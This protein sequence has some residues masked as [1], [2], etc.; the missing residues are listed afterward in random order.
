M[1]KIAI[2]LRELTPY[3]PLTIHKAIERALQHTYQTSDKIYNEV[4]RLTSSKMS[5]A[6]F[7]RKFREWRSKFPYRYEE[8]YFKTESG[9]LYKKF[10][11][12]KQ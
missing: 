9:S 12:A 6:T 5:F 3:K 10:R 8:K 2:N 1:S 4:I 11:R 7:D